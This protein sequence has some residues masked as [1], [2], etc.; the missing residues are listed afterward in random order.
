[1]TQD[2]APMYAQ[3]LSDAE[4]ADMAA[5]LKRRRPPKSVRDAERQRE[6]DAVAA[7]L[8]TQGWLDYEGGTTGQCRCGR[9]GPAGEFVARRVLGDRGPL[10]VSCRQCA[11]RAAHDA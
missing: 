10:R 6:A 11:A 5:V 3:E 4:R 8:L 2:Y 1:M 9:L 7:Y